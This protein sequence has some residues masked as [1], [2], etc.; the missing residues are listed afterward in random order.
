MVLAK[1]GTS[2]ETLLKG[3]DADKT[4]FSQDLGSLRMVFAAVI[5]AISM[6]NLGLIVLCNRRLYWRRLRRN[7][8]AGFGL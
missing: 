3:P 4:T 6:V 8:L 5:V 7:L 1:K 2:A